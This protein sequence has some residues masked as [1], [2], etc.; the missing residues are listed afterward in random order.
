VNWAKT[1]STAPVRGFGGRTGGFRFLAN[2]FI[3]PVFSENRTG[4]GTGPRLNRLNRPVG[5]VFK[6]MPRIEE[7]KK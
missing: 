5:P 3:F 1:G 6:T 4:L 7:K 2:F